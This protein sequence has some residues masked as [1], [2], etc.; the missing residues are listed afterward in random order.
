[1]SFFFFFKVSPELSVIMCSILFELT[2]VQAQQGKSEID[3]LLIGKI[4]KNLNCT[5]PL[6][7]I[8]R[9]R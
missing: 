3:S 2:E 7:F 8:L 1:M 9:S 6:C 5:V 4:T